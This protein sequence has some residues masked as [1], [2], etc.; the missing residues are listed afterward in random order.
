MTGHQFLEIV[1]SML[2]ANPLAD[3][4]PIANPFTQ[5]QIHILPLWKTALCQTP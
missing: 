5:F 4:S 3:H 1:I 2:M